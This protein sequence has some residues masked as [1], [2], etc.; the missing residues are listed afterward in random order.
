MDPLAYLN[1]S[2]VEATH[3]WF[4]GRRMLLSSAIAR[5]A[6]P[7]KARIL[8]IGCGTG[9]NLEMLLG[10]GNVSALEM[11]ATALRIATERL[12]GRVVPRQGSCPDDIPFEP[13]S[14]D[15]VCMFDVLEHIAD[16]GATLAAVRGLLA[17]GGRALVSVPAM[18]WLW[19][20]HDEFL[21]HQRRYT[22]ASLRAVATGAGL[23]PQRVTYFN[24]LLFPFAVVG[25]LYDRVRGPGTG[26]GSRLPPPVANHALHAV[27]ASEGSLLARAGLPFGAS[28][29][30]VLA[31]ADA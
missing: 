31:P 3:W 24:T 16:D 15:L 12:A 22:R 23:E 7:P 28:L 29:M 6:L 25:R 11:D 17:P 9:G 19:S 20:P 26:S 2:E 4:T 5:L 18:P 14:F 27:F 30:A 13:G 21:H 10:H 8:E 1:M